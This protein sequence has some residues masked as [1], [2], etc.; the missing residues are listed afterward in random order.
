VHE[1]GDED[2]AQDEGVDGDGCGETDAEF[3]DSALAAEDES[4]E[5]TDDQAAGGLGLGCAGGDDVDDTQP[6]C[7]GGRGG[8]DGSDATGVAEGT[9][10]GVESCCVAGSVQRSD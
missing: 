1:G 4:H 6:G 7:S 5:D 3:G 2:G 8:L 9:G 10:E